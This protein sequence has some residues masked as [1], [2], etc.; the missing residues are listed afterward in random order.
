MGKK[1]TI[2]TLSTPTFNNIRAA[3]ALP[4]HLMKGAEENENVQ[5]KIYSFNIN[6]LRYF[7]RVYNFLACV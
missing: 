3:S 6:K 4:Y 1:I 2:F 7:R 5:F